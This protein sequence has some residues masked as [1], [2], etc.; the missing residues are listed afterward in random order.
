MDHRSSLALVVF[1]FLLLKLLSK[2]LLRAWQGNSSH[3]IFPPGPTPRLFIGNLREIP[4]KLPWLTYTEWGL[5]YGELVHARV[6]GQHLV[7]VNSRK[8]AADLFDKRSHIYSDRPVLPIVELLGWD[9]NFGF[10][11]YGPRWRR[12]R[13]MLQGHFRREISL[14][15]RPIQ[16]EKIHD[17][18]RGLLS[19]PEDLT[20]LYKTLA[21]AIIMQT[22]Y[23]YQVKSTNDHFVTLSEHAAEKLKAS[24][25]PGAA[26]VNT[27]P[28]LRHFPGW[29]PG[30][31]FQR[32]AAECRQLT[33]E[34]QQ[35]PFEFVKQNMRN[36]IDSKSMTAKLLETSQAR[37]RSDERMIQEVAA[38]TSAVGSFFIAMAIYPEVQQKAQNEIDTVIG[39]NRLPEFED[40][41]SLPYTEALY[42]ELTRW[43]PV[44]PL[45][46][47]H[48]T[49]ADDIYEGYFIPKGKNHIAGAMTRDESVYP[50]PE[51]FKPERFFTADGKLN[52]DDVTGLA[53]GFGRRVCVGRHAADATVWATIVSVLSM[54][55]I[56]KAKDDAGND[57]E[58]DL[59]YSDGFI[60]H[61][62]PFRCSITPR[63][64]TAK[65]LVL[66]TAED[67]HGF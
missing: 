29:F 51:H 33:Q 58:I 66:G 28:I 36:G 31:G 65:K 34:M 53:F 8:T 11:P 9:F 7:L 62:P 61:P 43:R 37:G 16:M 6:L 27:F 30:C 49:S 55:N 4:T 44:L 64:E 45:G 26:A 22:V 23:G 10:M 1:C 32:I 42:R 48:A 52:D 67:M 39:T 56:A 35:V 2:K 63:T 50:D 24:T 17:F 5:Q 20:S 14:D 59:V 60:S 46:V 15:Y 25:L 54:F 12:H 47:A 3:L 18:L 40:R 19:R 38:T 57:I 41:P 13:R 21:A